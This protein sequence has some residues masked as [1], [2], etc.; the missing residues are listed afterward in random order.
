MVLL[1]IQ[2]VNKCRDTMRDTHR[3]TCKDRGNILK[4]V[5]KDLEEFS[6]LDANASL[7][8]YLQITI[9]NLIV[10]KSIAKLPFTPMGP[11]FPYA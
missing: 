1:V 9:S 5:Y 4:A 7:K 6:Q 10:L 8:I 3:T 11:G 2:Q